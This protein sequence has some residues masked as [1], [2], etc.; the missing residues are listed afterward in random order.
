MQTPKSKFPNDYTFCMTQR[1]TRDLDFGT[2]LRTTFF[3]LALVLSS[4]PTFAW[5][6]QKLSPSLSA[7][8][9]RAPQVIIRAQ[10]TQAKIVRN[11]PTGARSALRAGW[12]IQGLTKFDRD[13]HVTFQWEKIRDRSGS[14]IRVKEMQVM[15]GEHQ[16]NIW[17][18][19][20][21]THNACLRE[22]VLA[23]ELEHVAHH[24]TYSDQLKRALNRK[25]RFLIHGR[26]H[27]PLASSTSESA[28]KKELERRAKLAVL[29]LQKPLEHAA[30]QKDRRI[31]TPQHY[32]QEL[33]KCG[34]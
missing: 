15:I 29:K 1:E 12:R 2:V 5:S 10:S 26:T 9:A 17:L 22:V 27:L 34:L 23:H 21:I 32:A 14:C 19:P 31:D 24:K 7:Q 13:T 33:A 11:Q 30:R 6:A 4:A 28:A 16:P 20:S 8:C 3:M 25:L 18:A